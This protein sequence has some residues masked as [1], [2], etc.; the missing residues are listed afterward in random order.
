MCQKQHGAPDGQNR[1]ARAKG[2]SR[3]ALAAGLVA[4]GFSILH[5]GR[6]DVTRVVGATALF[7]YVVDYL[8]IQRLGNK[9]SGLVNQIVHQRLD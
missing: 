3:L 6:F 4:Q 2:K 8:F 5:S 9:K 1:R 7:T